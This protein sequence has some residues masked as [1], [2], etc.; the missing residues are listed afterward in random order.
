MV[1]IAIDFYIMLISSL[2]PFCYEKFVKTATMQSGSAC[3][4][5][6]CSFLH[7]LLISERAKWPHLRKASFNTRHASAN[8]AAMLLEHT[9]VHFF[10]QLFCFLLL[11]EHFQSVEIKI[12]RARIA[13]LENA[14]DAGDEPMQIDANDDDVV[15]LE[16]FAP[17]ATVAV[18]SNVDAAKKVRI[19][20]L[21]I[22]FLF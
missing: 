6:Y 3:C 13:E 8:A 18:A 11:F 22:F 4:A 1:K 16:A 9:C 2:N 17:P 15:F 19:E 7:L 21:N 10:F 12:L 20:L 5:L 14:S